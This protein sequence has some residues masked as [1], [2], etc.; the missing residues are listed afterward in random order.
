MQYSIEAGRLV[1]IMEDEDDIERRILVVQFLASLG[2]PLTTKQ[3][4]SFLSETPEEKLAALKN[5]VDS[6]EDMRRRVGF[7]E[8]WKTATLEDEA[9]AQIERTKI[10]ADIRKT[11]DRINRKSNLNADNPDADR[12]STRLNSSH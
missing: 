5:R 3:V 8:D 1:V 10:L 4:R 9:K 12:K 11:S 7:L 6:L 2:T